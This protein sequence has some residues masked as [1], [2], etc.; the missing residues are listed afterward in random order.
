LLT[1]R[2]WRTPHFGQTYA[3]F[4]ICAPHFSHALWSGVSGA[5]DEMAGFAACDM[6]PPF[7]PLRPLAFYFPY[8]FGPAPFFSVT[9][10]PRSATPAVNV[11]APQR[12]CVSFSTLS[13]L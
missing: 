13:F 11:P 9:T 5:A 3:I 1:G 7:A 6:L 2:R 8:F 12:Y 10:V 4:R